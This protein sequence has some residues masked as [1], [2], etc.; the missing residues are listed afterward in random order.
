MK[1]SGLA[2]L[3]KQRKRG[4]DPALSFRAEVENGRRQA[5]ADRDNGAL[6][7]GDDVSSGCHGSSTRG[8]QYGCQ[9]STLAEEQVSS[10]EEPH[11]NQFGLF[12]NRIVGGGKEVMTPL[13]RLRDQCSSRLRRDHPEHVPRRRHPHRARSDGGLLA[14]R[15]WRGPDHLTIGH[16]V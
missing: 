8:Q 9:L 13:A 11:N 12:V 15:Q 2:C 3:V 7:P 6:S 4:D 16:A 5:A 10:D 1:W 14:P